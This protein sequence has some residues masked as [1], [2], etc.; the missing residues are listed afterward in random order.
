MGING[1]EGERRF[2]MIVSANPISRTP[3]WLR[4][5]TLLC[6]VVLLPLGQ[7]FA[8]EPDYE[9]VGER[10]IKAVEAGELTPEQAS[11]MMGELARASFAK[12]LEAVR[13]RSDERDPGAGIEGHFLEMGVGK[14]TFDKIRKALAENG[15]QGKKIEKALGV[16]HRLIM[17]SKGDRFE[18]DKRVLS[19]LNDEIGLSREQIGLVLEL[20]QRLVKGLEYRARI[21]AAIKAGEM[22]RQGGLGQFITSTKVTEYP[23]PLQECM[24]RRNGVR[25]TGFAFLQVKIGSCG[26]ISPFEQYPSRCQ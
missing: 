1:G 8:Q 19:Y 26:P 13:G 10:L 4:A 25:G 23:N 24:M 18:P 17:G 15:I 5:V 22:S 21:L 16:M 7:A 9:A 20:T 6:A 14:E 11:A 3:R 2:K 12:R